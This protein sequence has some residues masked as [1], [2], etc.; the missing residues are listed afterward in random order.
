MTKIL[1][2]D[3]DGVLNSAKWFRNPRSNEDD[4]LGLRSIDP[5]CV[6]RLKKIL[7][8][9]GAKVVLSSTWRLEESFVKTLE[10][11]GIPIEGRTPYIRSNHRGEEIAAW[12]TGRDGISCDYIV[13]DDDDDAGD[14]ELTRDYFIQTTFATGLQDSH[15]QAAIRLLNG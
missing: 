11:A 14:H 1:F 3:V 5:A 12:L 15:V 8:F 4:Y 2:L 10:D 7:S 6:S 13:I 9:T